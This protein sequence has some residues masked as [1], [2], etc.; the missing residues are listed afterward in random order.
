MMVANHGYVAGRTSTWSTVLLVSALALGMAACSQSETQSAGTATAGPRVTPSPGWSDRE[1][2]RDQYG[3]LESGCDYLEIDR[4]AVITG[5]PPHLQARSRDFLDRDL[6]EKVREVG[7]VCEYF[8]DDARLALRLTVAW[9]PNTS[10]PRTAVLG[11]GLDVDPYRGF[12]TSPLNL[13]EV[14]VMAIDSSVAS[15][16]NPSTAYVFIVMA[17]RQ[18]FMRVD[19]YAQFGPDACQAMARAI[20]QLVP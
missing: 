11:D 17:K 15:S 2:A 10:R 3:L 7:R 8:G 6:D 4:I 12:K 14:A 16:R 19:C 9:E 13:G 1:S 20:A 5:E 18:Y